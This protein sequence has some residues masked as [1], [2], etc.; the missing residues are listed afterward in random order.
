M[1][2]GHKRKY[3]SRGDYKAYQEGYAKIDWDNDS[4]HKKDP[5]VDAVKLEDAPKLSLD[6]LDQKRQEAFAIGAESDDFRLYNDAYIQKKSDILGQ[7]EADKKQPLLALEYTPDNAFQP[8][9]IDQ[10]ENDIEPQKAD[11]SRNS[12]LAD[13]A[14]KLAAH[15]E[16]LANQQNVSKDTNTPSLLDDIDEAIEE[17]RDKKLEPSLLD[18]I[19]EVI[20]ASGEDKDKEPN[21]LDTIDEVI[22]ESRDKK[23]EPSLLDTIDEVIEAS[24]EDKDKE[25]NLLDTID[26]VIKTN[27]GNNNDPTSPEADKKKQSFF[28]KIG[29]VALNSY[30]NLKGKINAFNNKI[31][32]L[33]INLST[34]ILARQH[35]ATIKREQAKELKKAEK[36]SKSTEDKEAQR[37]KW[38][39]FA[40]GGMA[41]FGFTTAGFTADAINDYEANKSH[42]YEPP[43]E[44]TNPK[45]DKEVADQL[46]AYEKSLQ[47][48]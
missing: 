8:S 28:N 23:L 4:G 45:L 7:I 22:E 16:N 10:E 20:E 11:L 24:G 13:I 29:E 18:T 41:I 12:L 6:E 15:A 26:E 25:P 38:R 1:E 33:S 36:D 5:T 40:L 14:K 35:T 21:L 9:I 2:E 37:K 34:T 30:S 31:D 17:S 39:N 43:Q 32:T 19:D 27:S 46:T 47:G 48:K 42:A 44:Q 3:Y